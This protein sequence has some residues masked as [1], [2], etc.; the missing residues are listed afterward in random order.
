MKFSFKIQQ[1]QTDAVDAVTRVFQG[2][3]YHAGVSYMRDV[4]TRKES[5]RNRVISASVD[6]PSFLCYNIST[7][8]SAYGND[9]FRLLRGTFPG[10]KRG[11]RNAEAEREKW[12]EE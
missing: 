9:I 4:G 12:R 2:Q 1:Y 5:G 6:S 3:P 7:D 8:V 10:R 11:A